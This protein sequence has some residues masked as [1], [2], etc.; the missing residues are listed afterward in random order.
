MELSCS[1]ECLLGIHINVYMRTCVHA[2]THWGW[3]VKVCYIDFSKL[4]HIECG[5]QS[6]ISYPTEGNFSCCSIFH[7]KVGTP[8]AGDC[9]RTCWHTLCVRRDRRRKGSGRREKDEILQLGVCVC[10][11]GHLCIVCRYF[12]LA[13][14]KDHRMQFSDFLHKKIEIF[15]HRAVLKGSTIVSR[16]RSCFFHIVWYNTN[17]LYTPE[18][19]NFWVFSLLVGET[20]T[21]NHKGGRLNRL[22]VEIGCDITY[23]QMGI[24]T[25][26]LIPW[27]AVEPN[28]G[29]IKEAVNLHILFMKP[30]YL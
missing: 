11:C 2:D 3:C 12:S 30:S 13:N 24:D 10:V 27:G 6:V 25:T 1:S 20:T 19:T 23:T 14:S 7:S 28:C 26:S 29:T 9:Y 16:H 18:C 5:S 21:Y 4:H 15:F 8:I 22:K 17:I